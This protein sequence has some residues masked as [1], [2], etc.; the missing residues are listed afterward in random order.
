L[1]VWDHFRDHECLIFNNIRH[2]FVGGKI[3]DLVFLGKL[4]TLLGFNKTT[5]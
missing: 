3:I 5:L 2:L 4:P 1:M